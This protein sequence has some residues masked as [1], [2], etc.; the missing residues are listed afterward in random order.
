MPIIVIARQSENGQLKCSKRG[1]GCFF[2]APIS[3]LLFFIYKHSLSSAH[4][5]Q[6][7]LSMRNFDKTYCANNAFFEYSPCQT[8][9]N[10]TSTNY[11][12]LT[13][14]KKSKST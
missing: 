5:K 12:C 4:P 9:T 8:L 10:T 1:A 2:I 14:H 13:F 11:F 7:A 3:I 6:P